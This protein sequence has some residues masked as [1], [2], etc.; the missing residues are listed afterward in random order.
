MAHLAKLSLDLLDLF[1]AAARR[2]LHV[3]QELVNEPAFTGVYSQAAFTRPCINRGAV[4]GP[5]TNDHLWIIVFSL[6]CW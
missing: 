2:P 1:E 6:A 4:G 5:A 3:R